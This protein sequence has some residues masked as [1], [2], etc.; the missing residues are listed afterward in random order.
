M[1]LLFLDK[2][3]SHTKVVNKLRQIYLHDTTKPITWIVCGLEMNPL[4]P[5]CDPQGLFDCKMG[6]GLNQGFPSPIIIMNLPKE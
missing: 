6:F 3:C 2:I 1:K 4:E 5:N